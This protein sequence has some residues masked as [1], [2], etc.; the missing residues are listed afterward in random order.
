MEHHSVPIV[1]HCMLEQ[2]VK[3]FTVEEEGEPPQQQ[4]AVD[5]AAG[6]TPAAGTEAEGDDEPTAPAEEP[7]DEEAEGAAVVTAAAALNA[8]LGDGSEEKDTIR[9]EEKPPRSETPVIQAGDETMARLMGLPAGYPLPK[10][11][12]L[13]TSGSGPLTTIDGKVNV[14]GVERHMKEL[15]TYPGCNREGMPP[16]PELSEKDLDTALAPLKA[17]TK[18]LSMGL[19]KQRLLSSALLGLLPLGAQAAHAAEILARHTQEHLSA[20]V[21]VQVSLKCVRALLGKEA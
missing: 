5:E 21:M 18:G 9:M 6:T 12:T 15:L 8:L 3:S 14:P 19:V 16:H 4:Q 1:M 10:S 7:V 20:D 2:L 13:G 11:G 17:Q